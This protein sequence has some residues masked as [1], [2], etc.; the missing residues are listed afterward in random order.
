MRQ[1]H[2]FPVQVV[3]GSSASSDRHDHL[4]PGEFQGPERLRK[5]CKPF[6]RCRAKVHRTERCAWWHAA[7]PHGPCDLAH[8]LR[9]ARAEV[10]AVDKIAFGRDLDGSQHLDA[11][12]KSADWAG[13]TCQPCDAC[14]SRGAAGRK[15]V[16]AVARPE[17]RLAILGG[18][19]N[20]FP[21][22]LLSV[23][24]AGFVPGG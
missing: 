2:G 14:L 3:F 19:S 4:H 22:C 10:T 11:H 8:R 5:C 6:R 18:Y 15:C 9:A 13:R 17:G 24:A 23:E 12:L 20:V 16:G 7:Q 1:S 21:A